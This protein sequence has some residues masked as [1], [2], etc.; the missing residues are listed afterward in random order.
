MSAHEQTVVWMLGFGI[1]AGIGVA[2]F[3]LKR[4]PLSRATGAALAIAGIGVQPAFASTLVCT[5]QCAGDHAA[6]AVAVVALVGL[7]AA[8]IL[9]GLALRERRKERRAAKG[10]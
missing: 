1:L 3:V 4:R 5:G 7:L 8:P 6:G 2:L 10:T 9:G